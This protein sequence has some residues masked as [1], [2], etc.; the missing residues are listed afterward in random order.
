MSEEKSNEINEINE[1]SGNNGNGAPEPTDE[2]KAQF[3]WAE[4]RF[5]ILPES[6]DVY[7]RTVAQNEKAEPLEG[8]HFKSFPEAKSILEIMNEWAQGLF[9][10]VAWPF[11][12]P[13]EAEK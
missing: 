3:E 2:I 13:E 7:V 11:K 1:I 10:P 6:T 12:D 8:W 5:L 4:V 9:D